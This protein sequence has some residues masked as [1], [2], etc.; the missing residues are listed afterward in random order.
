MA[1]LTPK[2]CKD[3]YLYRI[4]GRNA[5]YGVWIKD[6]GI[7]IIRRH[8]FGICFLCQETHWDLDPTFGTAKPL[9]EMCRCC[10]EPE[11][12]HKFPFF[13]NENPYDVDNLLHWLG[14]ECIDTLEE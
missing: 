14:I 6:R 10:Y 5:D 9:F 3:G 4:T 13:K 1:H 11:F 2:Q 7:F 12:L 8:K